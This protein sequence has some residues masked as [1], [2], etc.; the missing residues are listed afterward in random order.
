[1][2]NLQFCLEI[3]GNK[4]KNKQ[5]HSKRFCEACGSKYKLCNSVDLRQEEMLRVV[6]GKSKQL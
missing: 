6:Q 2:T 5:K 3:N 4:Q 1:M